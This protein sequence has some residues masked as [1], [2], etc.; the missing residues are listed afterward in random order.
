MNNDTKIG[1]ISKGD[2][3]IIITEIS[4]ESEDINYNDLIIE[5]DTN[6]GDTLIKYHPTRNITNSYSLF[7]FPKDGIIKAGSEAH[8]IFRSPLDL[9]T[10]DEGVI[11]FRHKEGSAKIIKFKNPGPILGNNN[12]L[13]SLR[14]LSIFT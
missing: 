2:L 4:K 10:G 12:Y 1:K 6:K 14:D 3:F 9:E 13:Y 5:L 7:G 11:I 8:L